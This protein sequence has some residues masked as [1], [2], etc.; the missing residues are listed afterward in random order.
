MFYFNL[1]QTPASYAGCVMQMIQ[2]M[3]A[4]NWLIV[5]YSDGF[6]VKGSPGIGQFGYGLLSG[7]IPNSVAGVTGSM[8]NNG[9]WCLLQQPSAS[10][11]GTA[12]GTPYSGQRQLIVYRGSGDTA[13][14]IKYSQ[15]GLWTNNPL[16][17]G[18]I[19]V[20]PASGNFGTGSDDQI[21]I[22]GGTALVPAGG[23]WFAGTEGFLRCHTMAD[24]GQNTSVSPFGIAML[25]YS[26]GNQSPANNTVFLMDSML[27]A[28]IASGT[29]DPYVFY[30]SNTAAAFTYVTDFSSDTNTGK[31]RTWF[32]KGQTNQSWV[33]IGAMGV[34]GYCGNVL[35]LGTEAPQG[36]G[37]NSA[38]FWDDTYPIV[39]ARSA[40]AGGITGYKG[41][42]GMVSWNGS[43][44]NTGENLSLSNPGVSRDRIVFQACNLPWD[45]QTIPLV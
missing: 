40:A 16:N 23:T 42:S 29:A 19:L 44:R 27:T 6:S 9:A 1:N 35:A 33:G 28:S 12:T 17:T 32:R 37:G 11:S 8:N 34:V 21:I 26:N 7:N 36:L 25:C 39:W 4:A 20:P 13:W 38:N 15:G 24:D 10:I 22:G 2:T 41:I 5:S 18:S 3:V 30:A 31:P 45:G 43:T 14:M